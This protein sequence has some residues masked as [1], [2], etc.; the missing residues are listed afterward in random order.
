MLTSLERLV[1]LIPS[2]PKD[3]QIKF[4][5]EVLFNYPPSQINE[6]IRFYNNIMYQGQVGKGFRIIARM[7]GQ[8]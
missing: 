2:A 5:G 3:L 7:L 6:R 8:I 1:E 4:I